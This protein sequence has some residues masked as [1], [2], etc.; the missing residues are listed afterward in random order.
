MRPS[1][2]AISPCPFNMLL[3]TLSGSSKFVASYSY[4]KGKV[5]EVKDAIDTC[6]SKSKAAA[7][8]TGVDFCN[9]IRQ[10]DWCARLLGSFQ[11]KSLFRYFLACMVAEL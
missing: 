5:P 9:A 1:S 8:D 7:I 11:R 10:E 4:S 6:K 3:F 2:S